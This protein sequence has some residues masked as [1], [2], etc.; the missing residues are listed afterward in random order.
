MPCYGD[1]K[2]RLVLS[3]T[4]VDLMRIELEK[5]EPIDH[6]PY[7]PWRGVQKNDERYFPIGY[8]DFYQLQESNG[9][10]DTL[11]KVAPSLS[12]RYESQLEKRESIQL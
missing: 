3:S 10:Y 1:D 7:Y 11:E 12:G 2:D 8:Q 5:E 4:D 6:C 9:V